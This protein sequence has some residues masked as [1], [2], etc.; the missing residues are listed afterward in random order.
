MKPC[1]GSGISVMSQVYVLTVHY[2]VLS[3][4]VGDMRLVYY[5]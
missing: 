2:F 4:Y 5:L 1:T 3:T